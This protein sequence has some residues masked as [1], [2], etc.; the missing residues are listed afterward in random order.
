[1]IIKTLYNGYID[2]SNFK[3]YDI[4]FKDPPIKMVCDGISYDLGGFSEYLPSWY[5]CIIVHFEQAIR[6]KVPFFD[7]TQYCDE[8][9]SDENVTIIREQAIAFENMHRP[10]NKPI[11][12]ALEM[13]KRRAQSDD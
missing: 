4:D 1:M 8:D 2:L 5:Q 9:I 11:E 3:N 6:N 12:F 13:E 7:F 10:Y